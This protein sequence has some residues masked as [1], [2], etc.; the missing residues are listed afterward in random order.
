MNFKKV[1]GLFFCLVII[2]FLLNCSGGYKEW[3]IERTEEEVLM[4]R[5][6]FNQKFKITQSISGVYRVV[7][8]SKDFDSQLKKEG[9]EVFLSGIPIEMMP[10]DRPFTNSDFNKAVDMFIIS[11]DALVNDDLMVLQKSQQCFLKLNI[12][13]VLMKKIEENGK[14][15][16][17][18]PIQFFLLDSISIYNGK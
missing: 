1:S 18:H 12:T 8:F 13:G 15:T 11:N 2:S 17:G 3:E 4:T 5:G 14:D 10:E 9:V 7:S 16:T 6:S